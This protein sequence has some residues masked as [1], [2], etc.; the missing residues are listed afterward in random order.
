MPCCQDG[1]P[2]THL[3]VGIKQF[4]YDEMVELGNVDDMKDVYSKQFI[5]EVSNLGID[6]E[7]VETNSS[8]RSRHPST[9]ACAC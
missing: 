7:E 2:D 9:L 8:L 3:L 6:G 5:T 4:D 1:H